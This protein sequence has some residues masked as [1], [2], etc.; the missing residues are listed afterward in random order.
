MRP[1]QVLKMSD[2][3]RVRVVTLVFWALALALGG[4]RM[5]ATRYGMDPDTISYLDMGDA[6]LRHDWRMALN[7]D[8]NPLYA[9]I[10]VAGK[11]V[12][13]PG[14]YWEFPYLHCV[15]LALFVCGLA[16]FHFLLVQIQ[17]RN[18]RLDDSPRWAG[19]LSIPHWA[20]FAL[21]FTLYMWS[22]QKLID[23]AQGA[24]LCLAALLYLAFAL[25]LRCD[26]MPSAWWPYLTLGAILGL[27]YLTKAVMFP[28][29]FVFLATPF[30]FARD[31]RLVL[32]RVL[33]A[34]LVFVLLIAPFILALSRSRGRFT[35]GDSGKFT[36]ALYVT[37]DF[38]DNWSPPYFHWQG[39]FPDAGVPK[40]PT[41]KIFSS[42][43]VYEFGTPFLA[44]YGAWYDP[45]YWYEG[46]RARINVRNQIRLILWNLR[47]YYRL[48]VLSQP[49]LLTSVLVL[50]WAYWRPGS[51]L[52]DL[53]LNGSLLLP[54]VA[55]FG[56]YGLVH[57]VEWR[58]VA[59]FLVVTWLA[60]LT[61]IRLPTGPRAERLP[62]SV[63]AGAALVI[64]LSSSLR[65]TYDDVSRLR[66]LGVGAN[67]REAEQARKLKDFGIRP[68]D[69]VGF[70]GDTFSAY[71]ARLARVRIVAEITRKDANVFWAADQATKDR[72][73]KAFADAGAKAVVTN[74]LPPPHDG[75]Q[76][77]TDS[78]A[79]ARQD[80][81]HLLNR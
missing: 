79:Y 51:R 58:Y 57:Y 56:L 52:R 74:R 7:G 78:P 11:A 71:W 33:V 5:W 28:L 42:P 2:R 9:W 66:D 77:I 18:E 22:S 49:V 31:R 14:Q 6:Y 19:T 64:L 40:H 70:I 13:R 41:R 50:V 29:G 36:Y 44:T 20:L 65:E 59:P 16:A 21:G 54:S 45:T 17:R 25:L 75:W 34:T 62:A 27:G 8:W 46:I 60:A 26:E 43:D 48:F 32:P 23:F 15:N 53:A 38:R 81:I 30:V 39:G 73:L 10:L 47:E 80:S 55:A 24:D 63:V 1:P 3:E 4:L 76:R 72:A 61:A 12:F 69:R 67:D 68:G 35:F 37:M